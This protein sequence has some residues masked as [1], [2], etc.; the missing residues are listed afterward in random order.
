MKIRLLSKTSLLL[1]LLLL[2]T[3]LVL[4]MANI[5]KAADGSILPPSNLA[6]QL[7]TPDD[8]RLTWSSVYGATSYNVYEITEG[9]L[10]LLGKT[11][12]TS[13]S[14]SNLA[15]GSYRYVV[16]TLSSEGESGPSA[17]VSVDIDYPVMT[18]P[19]TLTRVIRNGNDIV[20]S[21][22]AS[23]YAE[24][25]NI[26]QITQ[27][28]QS[29]L[30]TSTTAR[31][32][33]VSN[34][35]AGQY[36]YTVSAA[37]TLYGESPTATPVTAE[38]VYPIMK[39]PGNLTYTIT[40][41]SDVTLKWDAAAYATNYKIYQ[42]TD[43][44]KAVISTVTATSVKLTNVP[45]GN[46]TYEVR[47]NSDRFGESQ[48]GSL[49]SGVISTVTMAAPSNFISKV[50]NINDIVLTWISVPYSTNYKIYQII[51]GEKILKS[52]VTGTTVTYS[53]LPGG[54]Y[55]YEIHS[56]SDRYGESEEG[57][58][59]SV[60]IVDVT[61]TAPANLTHR[62]Q[63][64]NDLVLTWDSAPNAGSYKVYQISNGQK[65]LKSTISAATVTFSNVAAGDY[66]YEVHSFSTRFGESQEGSTLSITVVHPTMLPPTNV[67]QTIKTATDFTLSWDASLYATSYKVYQIVNG[68]KTLKNTV[69]ATSVSFTNMPP[70]EYT[71]E[72]YS[73]SSRFG[74]SAEGT[75]LTMTLNGQ[76]L[77]TPTGLAYSINNGNDIYFRW[78]AVQYATSYK[79]YQLI[80]GQKVLKSTVTSTSVS[81]INM[82]AG[83]YNYIVHAYSA[84]LGESPIG[85]EVN[86]PLVFPTMAA[87]GNL[88]SKVQNGND[89]VLTWGAVQ[90]A[91]SYKVYELING[92][93]V[94]KSTPSATSAT[95]TKVAV[96]EHTYVVHSVSTRFGQSPEGSRITLTLEEQIMTAPGSPTY[97][98][99][100]GNDINLKWNAVTFAT[101]YK[102][103]Q[104]IDGQPV[105]KRTVTSTSTS[106]TNM[107]EGDYSYEIHSYSDRFG[108]SQEGSQVSLKL[109][110]PTMQAPG[111]PTY[112]I[113]NGNDIILRWNTAT[114]ATSYKVYQIINGQPV[115][116]RT[117][118]STTV[119]LTNMPEGDYQYKIHS[120][121]DRFG[122]SPTSSLLNVPLVW[123][124]VKAPTLTGSVFNANN[125]T[126][127]WQAVTWANEYRVYK[128]VG[129]TR[130]LIYKG[131][132]LNYKVYNLTEETHS[133][134]VTAYSTRFG[135]SL[136]S[137]Q[138][139]EKI[140]YPIMGIPQVNLKLLSPAS[141]LITWDFVTYANGY[142][143]YEVIDGK[144]V[145]LVENLNNLSYTVS[146]L[147]YADHVY[148]VT[149]YSNSF[150]ES[151]PSDNV[152]AKL[153]VDI[154]A[155][156]TTVNIPAGWTNQD[157]VITLSATDNES[158]VAN[159]YYSL[160]DQEFIAG[161]SFKVSQE[162]IH[163]VSFYSVDRVGNKE[164]VKT[165]YVKVD[166]IAPVTQASYVETWATNA[167]VTLTATDQHSGIAKTLYSVNGAE[168][169]EGSSLKVTTEGINKISF[170]SV[171][172]AGN[173]EK[174]QVVEIKIDRTA[175]V[176][177]SNAP[178]AWVQGDVSL[179][180]TAEDAQSGIAKT[181]YSVNGAEYVEGSSLKVTT[182]G[183]NKVS[184]YSVDQAG[185]IEK[186]QVVEVKIDRTAPV[187]TSNAPAA[188]IQGDVSLALT[189]EDAQSGIEKTLYS[190]NGAEYVEGSTLKVTTE[191]I[192]KVSF[193][194]V[195]LAGNIEKTQVIEVKIDRTAPV[196]TSNAPTAWVQGDVS[197]TLTASDSQSGAAKT[198]YSV[199]GAEYVV[200]SSLKVKAEGINKISFY[201]VDKAG[202][203]EKIQVVEVKI[204][205][206]APMLTMNLYNEYKLGAVVQ[207][208]YTASD[209][210][211]GIVSESMTVTGPNNETITLQNGNEL[212]LKQ[213]GA[214]KVSVTVTNAA[215][216]TT[217]LKKQFVVYIPATIEV[218]PNVIKGNKGV[219]T[220]RVE[221]PREYIGEGI[222]L[223]TVTLNGVK[224]LISNNGY[225]N[226]AKNG[227]FKFERADF[228]WSNSTETLVFRGY[229][230]G[231]LVIGQTT[232]KVQK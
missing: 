111:N 64:G 126:L 205:R 167:T 61:M 140:I 206:T 199:N 157:S 190:V 74:E 191:G 160:N 172:Q 133:F 25:Y 143:V 106:F 174:T 202:N 15:E 37:N 137:N 200:G 131:T 66:T 27:E 221:L 56:F 3:Q 194:S 166:K 98:L 80:D 116:S 188:W 210:L 175:P 129:T 31:T 60:A 103:Y 139:T 11:T 19:T 73:Y 39:A 158:G 90:Y 220:V 40:N 50:Q 149:S 225:Y 156:V 231:I 46:F 121:S 153:I 135:E 222:E 102:V 159:S 57:S 169:V 122:E 108:E 120:Y 136:A 69:S 81:Y 114:Y 178:V 51:N 72:V 115:L 12:T 70:G 16:S 132:A 59:V 99:T 77:Q 91:A 198:L 85:A 197:L 93:E 10:I 228:E 154:E 33:T 78:N 38:V 92:E 9:Q 141:A 1:A 13:Y 229:V 185:N 212:T 151:A 97:T 6:P 144:P 118:T 217:T 14:I 100:S 138:V 55:T 95:L 186:T 7:V 146:N 84:P 164:T 107:P 161:T 18:A 176:T 124:E 62:I 170:Y 30:L 24:N 232:V 96:G 216:L 41:G 209:N 227:Q 17:P 184:F 21:W 63:N 117:V 214:Y 145:L 36:T 183:I 32:Y 44:Q 187:T 88:T 71:F 192:N 123:P 5:A 53:Q 203:F 49:V 163:K 45:S 28:G 43:G 230:D 195:D 165:S 65:V 201:S 68:Q 119:A 207:L 152:I 179:A 35:P 105:F 79:V 58:T 125:I 204:D 4:P 134:E 47:S 20:L 48:D 130:E 147:S 162:G 82:S 189:A 171:D 148:Y 173:I 215:G 67:V 22:G 83:N 150:G 34:T 181:L 109:V 177:T 89:V 23:A 213:P 142:N 193:Y 87:P 223:D 113:T 208:N 52:T 218:T 101:A 224:A 86:I 54:E 112:S 219:F 104:V 155:P 75:A 76:T 211:S 196:T 26:F 127:V 168:Y 94:L 226:Q 110:Y 29:T 180:L 42:I 128:V 182:E 8:L 2:V